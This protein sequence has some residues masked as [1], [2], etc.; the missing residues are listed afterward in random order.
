VPGDAEPGE[1]RPDDVKVDVRTRTG[2]HEGTHQ[3][4]QPRI[5]GRAD[6]RLGNA[7]M[8]D[9]KVLDLAGGDV[10]AAPDDDVLL[11]VGDDQ[12]SVGVEAADIAG[13]EP[14]AR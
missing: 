13:P 4:A 5:R 9:Q 3:F 10:L 2:Q 11:A 1:M 6:G 8:P 14:A 12:V 7:G